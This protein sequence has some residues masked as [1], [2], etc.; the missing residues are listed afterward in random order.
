[1]SKCLNQEGSQHAAAF[2][3]Y[4][5]TMLCAVAAAGCCQLIMT[6]PL[7]KHAMSKMIFKI[8]KKDEKPRVLRLIDIS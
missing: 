1:M 7:M 5:Q 3:R 6:S 8:F 4:V 2:N